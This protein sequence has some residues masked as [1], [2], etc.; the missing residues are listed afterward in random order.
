MGGRSG[1]AHL[2]GR[3]KRERERERESSLTKRL[4]ARAH[5]HTLQARVEQL[6]E[7]LTSQ[8]AVAAKKADAQAVEIK[9]KVLRFHSRLLIDRSIYLYNRI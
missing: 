5:T 7:Q 9:A 1:E 2:V 6:E 8:E 3:T 4:Y